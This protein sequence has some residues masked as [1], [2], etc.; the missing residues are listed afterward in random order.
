[1]PEWA[2]NP[3]PQARFLACGA[4]EVLYGGA[5][6]GGKSDALV[7]APLRFVEHPRFSALLL[8][9][10]FPELERTLVK[11]S[12]EIYPT[13]GAVY[14]EARH[15]WRFPSGAEIAF[16]YLDGERDVRQYQGAEFQFLGFDE[17]THFSDAEYRYLL[18]RV[19]GPAELPKL[20]RAA[21]NPGGPGH[22]W[23]QRRWAPWLAGPE[24]DGPRAEPG[25]VLRVL[26]EDDGERIVPRGIEG[27]FSR[28]FI[29]ARVDDNPKGDPTYKARLSLLDAVTRAQLRDGN[30]LIRP[31]AGLYFKRSWWRFVDA[32]PTGR[33]RVVSRWDLAATEELLAE[34]GRPRNDPDWTVRVRMSRDADGRIFVE[35]VFRLRASPGEVERAIVATAEADGESVPVRIPQDPGA[36][37][38]F[39]AEHIIGRLDRFDVRAE[40][41]T[42][43]KVQRAAPFSAQA[44]AGNV[45]LVRGRWNEEFVSE[46]EAFPT[47]GV[48]DDQVDAASGAY[49]FLVRPEAYLSY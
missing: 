12:R 25:E 41:E 15:V 3:G 21:T 47:K 8:R 11:R 13:A 32:A 34:T 42:G 30:W 24:Y 33:S 4:F 23:V 18:S 16:G 19:R 6:G 43:D 35:D 1:M 26:P 17:L 38:K 28:T 27:S 5:A 37:G 39:A 40:P 2:P 10:S 20:V 22:E 29:A 9:R 14:S 46:L 48:H 7:I 49:A 36:A 45:V 44:E 31:A